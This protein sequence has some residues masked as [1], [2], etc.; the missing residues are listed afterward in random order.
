MDMDMGPIALEQ[1]VRFDDRH[2]VATQLETALPGQVLLIGMRAG[3]QLRD[4]RVA[5]PITIQVVRGEGTI[6][7]A[8]AVY[9]AHA[10]I[11]V[12]LGANVVHGATAVT[13]LVLLVHRAGVAE[14]ETVEAGTPPLFADTDPVTLDV[15]EL[16]PRDRHA[17][18]FATFNALRPGEA[19]RLV[20]DHDPKPLKYQFAAEHAG[21]A[22]WEPE[23][24]GPE[25]W[26]VR[27][28]KVAAGA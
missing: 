22:T 23:Q 4:H 18:I 26:V 25:V 14:A 12:S 15:R 8:D 19:L 2:P 7:A 27:I 9:P 5:T 16:A 24:E 21:E 13:D 11:F 3:Q 20:N 1:Q 28:G 6:T 17:R 10:G